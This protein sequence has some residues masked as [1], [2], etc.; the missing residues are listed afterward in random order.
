MIL[1]GSRFLCVKKYSQRNKYPFMNICP[2]STRF[3]FQYKNSQKNKSTKRFT[4]YVYSLLIP[5]NLPLK[6]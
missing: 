4:A 2:W 6:V 1:V 5:L 3:F